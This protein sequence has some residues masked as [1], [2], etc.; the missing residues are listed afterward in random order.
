MPERLKCLDAMDFIKDWTTW[1]NSLS[2]AI[3]EGKRVGLSDE[4]IQSL[5]VKVG[6]FLSEKVCP[7]NPE[8]A[9][10]KELWD[11]GTADERRALAAMIFK[12]V[13]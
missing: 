8:E 12:A 4:M 5:G 9:L 6:N 7:G 10:L 3:A 13:K 11:T 1:R 2:E